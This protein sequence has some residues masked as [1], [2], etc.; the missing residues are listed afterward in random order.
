MTASRL[1]GLLASAFAIAVFVDGA[2][3]TVDGLLKLALGVGP[4]QGMSGMMGLLA[5]VIMPWVWLGFIA[6]SRVR[7]SVIA[8]PTLAVVWALFGA[9][10]LPFWVGLSN[11]NL[12]VGLVELV[13][14]GVA[15]LRIRQISGG[16]LLDEE[17]P[18]FRLS[19]SLL[20]GVFTL[21]VLPA[22]TLTYG[23]WVVD[24]SL[25]TGSGG[26]VRLDPE[27]LAI[28]HRVYARDDA[29]LHLIGMM[30]IGEE[31]IYDDLYA[32]L[33]RE[34]S[35]VLEEGVSDR[36]GIVESGGG[37]G[38][39]AAALGLTQQRHLSDEDGLERRNADVDFSDLSDEVRGLIELTMLVHASSDMG[40]F[41]SRWQTYAQEVGRDSDRI[42]E[43]F[44]HDV[45]EMRND[46]V[47][48]ET[49]T[50]LADHTRVILPWGA[51]HMKGL[52]ERATQEGWSA[53]D[54]SWRVFLRWDT[55]TGR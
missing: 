32:S 41:L 9:M 27:G 37:Y 28:A 30:H 54:E 53:T 50:A 13:L 36:E 33:P 22:L 14:G 26:F 2:I 47:W 42:L 39:M 18:A 16:W 51:L 31:G 10:P 46:H 11:M 6:S 8:G 49:H 35:I 55:L 24:F 34:G 52:S 21:V 1:F 23:V 45:V 12:G 4:L 43:L 5:L 29:E 17:G 15:L 44:W 19:H 25:R 38:G 3:T 7:L 40:Q 48:S 20:A